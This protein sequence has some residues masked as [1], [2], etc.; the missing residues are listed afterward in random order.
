MYTEPAAKVKPASEIMSEIKTSDEATD[1]AAQEAAG[2]KAFVGYLL[3]SRCLVDHD[4]VGFGRPGKPV[5][6]SRGCYSHSEAWQDLLMQA[7][8]KPRTFTVGK[9]AYTLDRGELVASEHFLALKWNWSYKAVRGFVTK[10][11]AQS[12]L[13]KGAFTGRKIPT[14]SICNYDKYQI[15]ASDVGAINGGVGAHKV[16]KKGDILKKVITNTGS[17]V[18]VEGLRPSHPNSVGAMAEDAISD[19]PQLD[20]QPLVAELQDDPAPAKPKV[21]RT[22]KKAPPSPEDASARGVAKANL[23]AAAVD[24]AFAIWGKVAEE[25][26]LP[27]CKSVSAKRRAQMGQRLDQIGNDPAAFEEILRREITASA[28]LQGKIKPRPG[29]GYRQFELSIDFVLQPS[30]WDKFIDGAYSRKVGGPKSTQRLDIDKLQTE[31]AEMIAQT[32]LIA[33]AS[34]QSALDRRIRNQRS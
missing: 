27:A 4:V 16:A 5:D 14:L 28:F 8:Y 22:A 24:A 33:E 20:L 30:S 2:A 12:M 34:R 1:A 17:E 31:A 7:A 23:K 3:I 18:R 9:T 19:I 29:S 25:F 11:R 13:K 6:P 32:R 21:A 10:L 26:K 15:A